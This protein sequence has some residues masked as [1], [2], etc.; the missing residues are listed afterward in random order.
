MI[1]FWWFIWAQASIDTLPLGY[2]SRQDSAYVEEDQKI[3]FGEFTFV[4]AGQSVRVT[5]HALLIY[6]PTSSAFRWWW[7]GNNTTSQSRNLSGPCY[8]YSWETNDPNGFLVRFF[9]GDNDVLARL[10]DDGKGTGT[11]GPLAIVPAIDVVPVKDPYADMI[12]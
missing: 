3:Y 4:P 9:D 2:I 5:Y 10:E 8:Y 6:K 11:H 12:Q 7:F 1:F